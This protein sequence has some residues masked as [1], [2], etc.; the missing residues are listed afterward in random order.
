MIK[1]MNDLDDV[2]EICFGNIEMDLDY[3]NIAQS[4]IGGTS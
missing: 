1:T 3:F 2:P 4:R